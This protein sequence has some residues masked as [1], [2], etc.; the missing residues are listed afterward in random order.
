M[1]KNPQE[2]IKQLEQ[3]VYAL[4]VEVKH[5]ADRAKRWQEAYDNAM[6]YAK[7]LLKGVNHENHVR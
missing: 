1:T 4:K 6:T 2:R 3:E 5:Q 7:N